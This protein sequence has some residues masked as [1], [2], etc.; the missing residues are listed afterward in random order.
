MEELKCP[1]CG[2]LNDSDTKKCSCGYTF[3]KELYK[4]ELQQS[5]VNEKKQ[6]KANFF[7][8]NQIAIIVFITLLI[9]R[10]IWL[11]MKADFVLDIPAAFLSIL[12]DS[13]IALILG[14][15][16]QFGWNKI[17]KN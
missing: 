7:I 9:I 4:K 10:F 3:D 14:V 15:L 5:Q 12:I 13:P 16:A 11:F 6:R 17:K 1:Y 2:K 8:K